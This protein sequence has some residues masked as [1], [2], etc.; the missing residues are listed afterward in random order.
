MMKFI[1]IIA[2]VTVAVSAYRVHVPHQEEHH[3]ELE[4]HHK[5]EH[6]KVEHHKIEHHQEE[7]HIDVPHDYFAHAKYKFDYG[8]KDPHT[9]DHKTHWEERD[10]DVVKGAYTLFD[11]DG[12][13]R[14]VEYTAD[15][16]HGFKAVVKKV[17]HE[18]LVHHEPEK[19]HHH[20]HKH[21][22]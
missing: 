1:C 13:T 12:S 11:A 2:C 4:K 19:K 10:G 18:P 7:H 9:G 17:Q 21:L 20:E 8:V 5:P 14:I 16:L 22:E 6:H 3:V 15:P